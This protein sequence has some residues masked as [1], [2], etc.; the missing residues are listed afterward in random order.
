VNNNKLLQTLNITRL[1][2]GLISMI[3]IAI[4]FVLRLNGNSLKELFFYLAIVFMALS[5][6]I[7]LCYHQIFKAIY[8]KTDEKINNSGETN[9][10]NRE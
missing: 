10:T 8:S 3:C 1:I 5:L 9:D 4:Y 6:L 7:M 2:T